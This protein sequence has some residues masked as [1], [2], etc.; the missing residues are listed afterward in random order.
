MTYTA[1]HDMIVTGFHSILPS[2]SAV[3]AL[4]LK[5]ASH[6]QKKEPSVLRQLP[7]MQTLSLLHSSTSEA[8]RKKLEKGRAQDS[9]HTDFFFYPHISSVLSL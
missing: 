4:Y 9:L 3:S 7:R 1:G 5:P 6:K 8:E 2:Q